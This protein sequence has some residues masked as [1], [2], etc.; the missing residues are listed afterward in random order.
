MPALERVMSLL[1]EVVR[2]AFDDPEVSELMINGPGKYFVER[3]GQQPV[4]VEAPGLTA[5]DLYAAAIHIARPLGL[6][7]SEKV[8]VVDARLDDGSRVAIVLPPVV[9]HVAITIRRF[10]GRQYSA[11]DLV[12]LG[13]LPRAVLDEAA[14]HLRARRNVLIAGGT[15]SGKTTLLQAL[16]GLVPEDERILVIEDTTEIQL[17]SPNLL[18]MEARQLAGSGLSIRDL[19]KASLRHRPDR[20]ILGEVRGGE[21]A[22]LIQAL[23]T[24][25]GGSL[26]TIHSNDAESALVRLASCALQGSEGMSW[27]VLCMQVAQAIDFVVHVERRDGKRGVSSAVHVLGAEGDGWETRRFWPPPGRG[28]SEG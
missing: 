7:A 4:E 5:D 22:D 6:D 12:E 15:G 28:G 1:P 24:G 21:A 2:K 20:L 23:N 3:R 9:K 14:E 26:S 27:P 19:V 10:G 18:Q 17:E 25:H 13:S 11:E 8:P 16:A